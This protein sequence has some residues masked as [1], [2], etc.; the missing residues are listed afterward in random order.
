M[1]LVIFEKKKL[2]KSFR[3]HFSV[4]YYCLTRL[5]YLPEDETVEEGE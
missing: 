2:I 1:S 4:N 5:L 3:L